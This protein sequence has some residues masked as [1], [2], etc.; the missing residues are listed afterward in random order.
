MDES[1]TA[2]RLKWAYIAGLRKGKKMTRRAWE[3]MLLKAA[4]RLK[5][6]GFS[7]VYI[8]LITGLAPRTIKAWLKGRAL[9]YPGMDNPVDARACIH[10]RGNPGPQIVARWIKGLGGAKKLIKKTEKEVDRQRR[11]V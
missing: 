10:V 5:E 6:D 11:G 9:I 7:W 1:D 8:G 4:I 2:Q 3:D